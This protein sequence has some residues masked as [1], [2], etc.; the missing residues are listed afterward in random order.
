[1]GYYALFIDRDGRRFRFDTRIYLCDCEDH[2]QEDGKG[3]CL[4]AFVGLNPGSAEPWKESDVGTW[5]RICE[6][7]TLRLIRRC[8]LEAGGREM[9]PCAFVQVWN[10]FYLCD[11]ESKKAIRDARKLGP[12][13][14]CPREGPLPLKMVWYGWG[15]SVPWLE[16]RTKYFVD[17]G[18]EKGVYYESKDGSPKIGKPGTGS[19]AG[20]PARK[21]KASEREMQD[22]IRGLLRRA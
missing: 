2:K 11:P 10:L 5:N 9:S 4:G 18:P 12:P 8:F 3:I 21:P 7:G 6:D 22:L 19:Y 1:M 15:S 16:N 14:T 20:H 13:R 17:I